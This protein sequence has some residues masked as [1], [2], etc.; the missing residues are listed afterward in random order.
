[1]RA[2][3]TCVKPSVGV[4]DEVMPRLMAVNPQLYVVPAKT[5]ASLRQWL[6]SANISQ[7]A[8]LSLAK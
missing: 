3:Y 7:E 6:H 5:Q 2:P 8:P 4:P 1:M